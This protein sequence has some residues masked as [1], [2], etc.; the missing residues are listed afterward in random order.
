LELPPERRI[1]KSDVDIA[2]KKLV[3][4]LKKEVLL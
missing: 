4:L 2:I 1:S 3:E